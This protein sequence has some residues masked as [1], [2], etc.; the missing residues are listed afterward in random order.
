MPRALW[1]RPSESAR[2]SPA[3]R[4]DGEG[5]G[6]ERGVRSKGEGGRAPLPHT[7]SFG[8]GYGGSEVCLFCARLR[9]QL[10]FWQALVAATAARGTLALRVGRIA[11][12]AILSR[13]RRVALMGAAYACNMACALKAS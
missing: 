7:R 1:A 2:R 3:A 11:S 5:E 10:R 13:R 8:G 9:V 6:E 4:R 12:R